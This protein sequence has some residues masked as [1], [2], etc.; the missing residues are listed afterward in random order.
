V[1]PISAAGHHAPPQFGSAQ[2]SRLLQ[3]LALQ[4]AQQ[5][6]AVVNAAL[7]G[8]QVLKPWLLACCRPQP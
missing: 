1:A 4:D 3:Q 5:Q 8:Q 2:I 7:A 6:A